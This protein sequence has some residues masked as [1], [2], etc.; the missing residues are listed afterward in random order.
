[1]IRAGQLN[2]RITI[3]R[4]TSAANTVGELVPTW[5]THCTVWA[6]KQQLSG[7]ERYVGERLRADVDTSW[8]IRYRAGLDPKTM[9]I[10]HSGA[11]YDLLAVMDPDGRRVELLLLT[12]QQVG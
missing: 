2:Q 3:Q 6:A 10:S 5:T 1:M 8:R 9:R 4:K 11:I 12:F 7:R